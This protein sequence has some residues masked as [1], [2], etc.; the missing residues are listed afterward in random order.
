MLILIQGTLNTQ[1]DSENDNDSVLQIDNFDNSFWD[2]TASISKIGQ[3]K[4]SFR[5]YPNLTKVVV[6]IITVKK[7]PQNLRIFFTVISFLINLKHLSRR[8]K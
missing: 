2:K 3:N 1:L 5:I 4:D 8:I 6:T 7:N